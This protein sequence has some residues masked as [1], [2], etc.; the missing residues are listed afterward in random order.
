MQP[1]FFGILP[2]KLR[3]FVRTGDWLHQYL[4]TVGRHTR[5]FNFFQRAFVKEQVPLVRDRPWTTHIIV[6]YQNSRSA[7]LE[8]EFSCFARA[9]FEVSRAA[10]DDNRVGRF[11]GSFCYQQF[12]SDPR[13]QRPNQN[14]ATQN[15]DSNAPMPAHQQIPWYPLPEGR[16]KRRTR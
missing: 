3:L 6:G 11:K 8:Q 12:C 15:F 1:M 4:N 16:S 7:T 14:T 10:K 2:D 13:N 9:F 5:L